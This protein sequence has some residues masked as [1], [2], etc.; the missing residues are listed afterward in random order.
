MVNWYHFLVTL[1]PET[2]NPPDDSINPQVPVPVPRPVP[3][4]VPVPVPAPYPVQRPVP[5]PVA[6][7]PVYVDKPYGVPVSLFFF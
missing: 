5:V 6:S 2:T 3:V 1:A 4:Q 7:P